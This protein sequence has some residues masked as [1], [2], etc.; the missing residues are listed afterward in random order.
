MGDPLN[1]LDKTLQDM[2]SC[3]PQT[4]TYLGLHEYDFLY[5]ELGCEWMSKCLDTLELDLSELSS[6]EEE[7]LELDIQEAVRSLKVMQITTGFW[8]Y[9]KSYPIA[10]GLI[11]EMLISTIL[12]NAPED[13][14]KKALEARIKAIPRMLENSK[15]MLSKPKKVWVQLARAEL[16][17]LKL[18]LLDMNAP[19][20]V[21]ESLA[22]Y[23]KWLDSLE[24]EE[25]FEPIGETLFE[26]LLRIRG[27]VET[28]SSLASWARSEARK[29]KEELGEEPQGKEVENAKDVYL[30]AVKR[31]KNFVIEKKV[32]PLALDEELEAIDT[33]KPLIP[34]IPYAAYFPPAPFEWRNLGYLSVTPGAAKREYY[35]ILNTAVHETYPG[36]HL[37]LSLHLPTRYRPIVA[38]ATDLIEGWAHYTEELMMEL[39]FE[40]NPR[41]VWQV[42]K[43]MLWRLVRVYVDVELSTG[44][45]SFEEAVKEL[46]EVAM[47]DENS[48]KAEVLRY[49]LSPGYQL[50]YA[51]GKRRIKE[52]REEVKEYLG[53]KFS[54]YEFH[55]TLLKEGSLPVDVLRKLIL[56]EVQK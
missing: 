6:W 23:D 9:W 56:E 42:K 50:S 11:S 48:A 47:L 29:L 34:T 1:P 43:D 17:G 44:K 36:H 41:Y 54:L 13:F 8:R 4:A 27:I 45:M 25:G 32:A 35:D 20:D 49:T 14:K 21:L 40:T 16:N 33:P 18:M 19:N 28:P 51:Y 38:N 2:F 7:K 52:M 30:E 37:Q 31:A 5:P 22:E 24:P 12:R 46:V 55:K 53:S 39:G 26:E 3:E 10:P 15:E